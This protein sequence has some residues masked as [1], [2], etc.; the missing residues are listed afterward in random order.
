MLHQHK[1]CW[2]NAKVEQHFW[3]VTAEPAA[4]V[5]EGD[6][7]TLICSVSD[8]TEPMR[9]VWIN[10]DGETVGEKSLNGEEKSLS[11]MMDKADRGRGNWTCGL[12]HQ[13]RLQLS[14]PDI[15]EFRVTP[16]LDIWIITVAGYLFVKLAVGLGLICSLIWMSRV[17]ISFIFPAN[18]KLIAG[19]QTENTVFIDPRMAWIFM[20]KAAVPFAEGET[21]LQIIIHPLTT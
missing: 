8:V 7:V 11:L 19:C 6:T 20:I 17:R 16:L 21:Y 3:E 14:V 1:I 5:T 4:A 2:R 15:L 10:G 13:S 12:F 18:Q 9:L